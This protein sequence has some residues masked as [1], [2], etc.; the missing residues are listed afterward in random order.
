[1]IVHSFLW[2]NGCIYKVAR[3]NS[4]PVG[5]V[6]VQ[7]CTGVYRYVQEIISCLTLVEA[8]E[9]LNIMLT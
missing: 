5:A 6:Q 2:R 9:N 7:A 8:L 3:G 4:E 1:M